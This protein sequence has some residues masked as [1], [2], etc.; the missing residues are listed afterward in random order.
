MENAVYEEII[1]ES[2]TPFSGS[3]HHGKVH[4]RPVKGQK[5]PDTMFVECSKEL[6]NL[7]VFPLGSR[8]LLRVK[9]ANREGGTPYL[10]SNY[11]WPY[12]YLED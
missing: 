11:H 5:Y 6:S 1:V 10:Y 8:F 4:I 2:F 7:T 3:G 9:I 12:I